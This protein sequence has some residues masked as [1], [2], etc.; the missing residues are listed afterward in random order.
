MK[1]YLLLSAIILFSF[2]SFG[3]LNSNSSYIRKNFSSD[4]EETLKKHALEKWKTDYE[5]VV[6]YINNQADALMSLIEEFKSENTNIVY[7]AIQNWSHS[8]YKNSN[9]DRFK[10]LDTFGL[11][12]LLTLHCDW[13]MV[14]YEYDNQVKAK[15]SF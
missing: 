9:I 5:M 4:Y 10:K 11:K 8:G 14:K 15:N 1:R 3:Q 2:A 12:Q 13:E 7:K 6:Y